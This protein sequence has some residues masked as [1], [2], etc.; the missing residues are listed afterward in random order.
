MRGV[1]AARAGRPEVNS[2][3]QAGAE[4]EPIAET[5]EVQGA[6]VHYSITCA[7]EFLAVALTANDRWI[8]TLSRHRAS[9]L[10]RAR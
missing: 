4:A 1:R 9:H 8:N 3:G 6:P 10:A 5:M 7:I 2:G